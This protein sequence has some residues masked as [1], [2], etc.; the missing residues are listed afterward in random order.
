M[1]RLLLLLPALLVVVVTPVQ[2]EKVAELE[3]QARQLAQR[4][5]SE[6][7]PQLKGALAEGGPAKAIEVCARAAPEL[8][9]SLSAS[10]GWRVSRV[11][12]KARN[13]SRAVPDTWEKEVLLS[14]D[15]QRAA[16]A[17][18]AQLTRSEIVRGQYRF[19]QAQLAEG[20]C[21][22]CHGENLSAETRSALAD[23]YPGDMATG[24]IAG[25]VRGAISLSRPL[26]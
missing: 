19:M 13:A 8:A 17:E 11:S 2:A 6:L 20:L 4:F 26:K 22:T 5:I 3:P 1:T 25:Q 18:P 16:G 12:L 15:S 10:S 23:Y 9:D 7:K 14:F 24:Y 21:L